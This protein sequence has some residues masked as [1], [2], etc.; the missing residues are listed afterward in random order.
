MDEPHITT[1]LWRHRWLVAAC[2]VAALAAAVGASL[3]TSKQYEARAILQA[4]SSGDAS[5][6]ASA[7]ANEALAR[8]YAE[9][10]TS[11]S[12]FERVR[13]SLPGHP[14]VKTLQRHVKA[15]ALRDTAVV[16]LKVR[17][18][19]P[20]AARALA[21][22]I[23]ASFIS[24]L[25]VDATESIS[26]QQRQIDSLIAGL[27][28]RID[29]PAPG[30]S[31]GRIDQLRSSRSALVQQGAQLVADGVSQAVSARRVGPPSAETD[32][33]IP[34][35]KLNLLAGL[36]LGL[37]LGA[38]LAWLRERRN[39]PLR[40]AEDA[41]AISGAPILA[42]I[43]LRRRVMPN[44]PALMEAYDILRVNL[45][46]QGDERDLR[47]I[48]VVS[49]NAK[50]GKSS[51]AEGLA[52]AANRA[53]VNVVVVDADLRLA[54]LSARL[55]YVD[56]PTLQ[57]AI[58]NGLTLNDVLVELA[59]GLSLLPARPHTPDPPTLLNS[60]RMHEIV[61]L[62][63]ARFDLVI[64]DSPPVNRLADGLLL[65]SQSDAAV[66]VVKSGTTSRP[67][68]QRGARRVR[69]THVPIAGVVA[70]MPLERD[71]S[72]YPERTT[73]TTPG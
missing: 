73:A 46:F 37:L 22:G 69:Q 21:A 71:T 38:A 19:S 63:R 61:T 25:R 68:V 28:A 16:R 66:M 50:V 51:V 31:Q 55:N 41:S 7:D 29:H 59:P 4:G 5:S 49:E 53:G 36:L 72:Y 52:K 48:T 40:S 14:S 20:S 3:L 27:T 26:R 10:L 60:E 11:G 67:D 12:F 42:T 45:M 57:E 64:F 62:L 47:V 44:D 2:V 18:G 8:T 1:I 58:S 15:D 70:F 54:Q 32:P 56:G 24:S 6:G 17:A 23:T 30:T 65:A 39:L 33:V 35:T 9:V 13:G 34:R 43:P